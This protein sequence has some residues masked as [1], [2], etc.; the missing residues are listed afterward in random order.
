[1]SEKKN[2]I[3][4]TITGLFGGGNK[5]DAT[6]GTSATGSMA[7]DIM[8]L[9]TQLMGS[10][11]GKQLLSKFDGLKSLDTTQ[12]QTVLSALS[13]SS[14]PQVQSAKSDL[15]TV[16]HDGES[17]VTKLKGYASSLSQIVPVLLPALKSIFNK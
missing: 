12:I 7:D 1:M 17:F 10:D 16:K 13:K 3:L 11:M 4:D 5:A 8:N 9:G 15:E 14:D 2:G 6:T